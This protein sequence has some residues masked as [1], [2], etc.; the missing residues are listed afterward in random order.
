MDADLEVRG[1][2]R[3]ALAEQARRGQAEAR[4]IILTE[5][6]YD[7]ANPD[8]AYLAVLDHLGDE[9]RVTELLQSVVARAPRDI[10]L[11][12]RTALVRRGD[13]ESIAVFEEMVGGEDPYARIN[14]LRGLA[15]IRKVLGWEHWD[16]IA[17]RG[18]PQEVLPLAE[19][20]QAAMDTGHPQAVKAADLLE[21][22]AADRTNGVHVEITTRLYN[23]LHPWAVEATRVEIQQAVGGLLTQAA[24]RVI[25]GPPEL[26]RDVAELALERLRT[27]VLR[28]SDSL[29]LYRLL[30]HAAPD[31]A[32]GPLVDCVL[33][34]DDSSRELA[35]LVTT[36]LARVGA[37]ALTALERELGD[38]RADV[39]FVQLAGD[40]RSGAALPGLERLLM[41]ERKDVEL[42]LAALDCL[43]LLRDGPRAELLRTAADR[44]VGDPQF[45][46][47]ARLIFWNYL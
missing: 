28:D 20:M 32:A 6:A 26:Q 33:G 30:A 13:P 16:E 14:A 2:A 27:D 34:R 22:L 43:G 17:R 9:D 21:A 41:D 11:I 39:L 23:R 46:E 42:R 10:G 19:I 4:G 24:D 18:E 38:P 31:L 36:L 47:R 44:W 1:Y 45:R 29:L 8:L 15:A 3:S 40:L 5:L 12:A 35:R 7:T 37:P 25:A